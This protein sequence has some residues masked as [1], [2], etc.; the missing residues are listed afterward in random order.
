M[1]VAF[2]Q[3]GLHAGEMDDDVN[4]KLPAGLFQ[5]ASIWRLIVTCFTTLQGTS[6][7]LLRQVA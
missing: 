3:H 2:Q 1:A 4:C 7:T 6:H 5:A